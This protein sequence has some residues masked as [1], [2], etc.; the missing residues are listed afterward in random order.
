MFVMKKKVCKKWK[1]YDDIKHLKFQQREINKKTYHASSFCWAYKMHGTHIH[2][3]EIIEEQ[4]Q[5]KNF[6]KIINI[7]Y[8]L[9]K[10]MIYLYGKRLERREE[11]MFVKKKTKKKTKNCPLNY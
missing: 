2:T 5:L 9:S 11:Y 6:K 8:T 4:F 3:L 10:Y 7:T 1:I